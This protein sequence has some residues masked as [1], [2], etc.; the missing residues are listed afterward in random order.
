MDGSDST[1]DSANAALTAAAKVNPTDP[2]NPFVTAAA[3]LNVQNF[4][5][6]SVSSAQAQVTYTA[7]GTAAAGSTS[8]T[9]SSTTSQA[10]VVTTTKPVSGSSKT[11]AGLIA[12]VAVFA[13]LLM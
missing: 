5:I 7:V 12:V 13:T 8:S 2:T 11:S 10:V 9:T 3:T 1:T 4:S 6:S